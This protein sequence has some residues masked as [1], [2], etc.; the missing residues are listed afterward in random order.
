VSAPSPTIPS[1]TTQPGPKVTVAGVL[2][3]L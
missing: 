2:E 1:C 3:S